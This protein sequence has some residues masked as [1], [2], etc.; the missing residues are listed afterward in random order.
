[1]LKVIN[2]QFN[3]IFFTVLLL[4]LFSVVEIQDVFSQESPIPEWIKNNAGWW[5]EGQIDD[6]T[7]IQGI[8]FLIE[9]GIITIPETEVTSQ[10]SDV[11]PEW[12]KNNAGW[13]AEGQ[14]D[15]STFIQGIQFLVGQGIISLQSEQTEDPNIN[16]EGFGTSGNVVVQKDTGEKLT[17]AEDRDWYLWS[18]VIEDGSDTLLPASTILSLQYTYPDGTVTN[19]VSIVSTEGFVNVRAQF[20]GQPNAES[21]LITDIDGYIYEEEFNLVIK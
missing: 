2:T 14:I 9:N 16:S 10:N 17:D 6:G 1:M 4:G 20:S 7:F 12:V 21:I 5:A 8:Q 11:V 19:H 15:D 18:L 3:K 13:W